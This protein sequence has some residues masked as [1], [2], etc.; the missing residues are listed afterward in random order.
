MPPSTTTD[1]GSTPQRRLGWATVLIPVAAML[2]VGFWGLN[3]GSMW[4]DE[5]ATFDA[6]RRP[7]GELWS[8]VHHVD[9][10]HFAYYALMHLWLDISPTEVWM[11]VPSVL[12]TAASAGLIAAIGARLIGRRAG[13]LSGLVFA[14]I[15]FVSFYAQEGRSF[16]LVC[17]AVLAGCYFLVRAVGAVGTGRRSAIWW[18][19]YAV[20]MVAAQTLHEFAILALP[21]HAIT[22]LVSRAPLKTWW[23]WAGCALVCVL[24]VA[25][26]AWYSQRQSQQVSWLNRPSWSTVSQLAA[27]FFGP[28][29]AA[30]VLVLITVLAG[31][32]VRRRSGELR[33]AALALPLMIAPPALLLIVSLVHPLF[34]DRYVLYSVAGVALLA[35]AGLDWLAGL[36][37]WRR[38]ADLVCLIVVAGVFIAQLAPLRE[39]RTIGSRNNDLAGAARAVGEGARPGDG[40]IF[41]PSKYRA[42]A[43]AYPHA[44]LDTR[45]L[46]VAQSPTKSDN[47]RGIDK[48]R[49]AVRRAMRAT[50]RIWV[51]GRSG[52]KARSNESGA[53][54]ERAVLKQ[55]FT[56]VR[57]VSV[58]GM[59]IGLFVRNGR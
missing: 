55:D 53:V 40:V 9:I 21:A 54:N 44:F 23:R 22:L 33:I 7:W 12:A 2:A 30:T 4:Q 6:A 39:V 5:E 56:M 19:G 59:E 20:A 29:T 26:L 31:L 58:H 17:A 41:M 24:A 3:R 14:T 45:D 50:D 36:L 52:L 38:P 37:P 46:A 28:T 51:V 18:F 42:A 8:M 11:R 34:V 1:A 16:A 48:S 49:R 47:L 13:L 10:V 25:P 57:S 35:G 15:P 43:L 27:T 32:I